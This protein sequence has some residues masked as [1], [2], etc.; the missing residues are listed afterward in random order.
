MRIGAGVGV[1]G[2]CTDVDDVIVAERLRNDNSAEV[3]RISGMVQSCSMLLLKEVL[4]RRLDLGYLKFAR[5]GI[6]RSIGLQCRNL[7]AEIV[8]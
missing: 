6:G 8:E 7:S 5:R 1:V 4:Q 2:G 3:L